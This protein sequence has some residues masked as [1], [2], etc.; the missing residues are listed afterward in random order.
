[1]R[2]RRFAEPL[3]VRPRNL[4]RGVEIK[5]K[6]FPP[7]R[8]ARTD[9]EPVVQPLRITDDERLG[10]ENHP[11]PIGSRLADQSHGLVD[12]GIG[13][14]RDGPGLDDGDTGGGCF[15]FG[16]HMSLR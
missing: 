13:V 5:P 12:A 15:H 2:R 11:R 16:R 6:L 9:D 10:K 4:D 7:D 1:M 8:V 3:R 14:E